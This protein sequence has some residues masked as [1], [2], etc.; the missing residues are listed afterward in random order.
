[1]TAATISAP[2]EDARTAR[3]R[4]AER[5][6]W[7]HYGLAPEERFVDVGSPPVRIRVVEVGSGP[8]V[9]VAHGTAG[10]GPVAAALLKE[11]PDRRFLLMD[12][13]GFGLSSPIRYSART[14]KQTVADLQRDVLDAVGIERAD[15]VGHSI[16]GVFALRLALAHPAR[17]RRVMLLGAGAIVAEAGVPTIIRLMASPFGAIMVRL[18]RSRRATI[19]MIRGSGHGPSLNDGR[20]PDVFVDWRTAVN[21]DTDSMSRE[22]DM[23]R[24]VVSGRGYRPELTL[25]DTELAGITQ[26][27][28]MLYGTADSVGSRSVWTRVMDVIP[29]GRLSVV[30]GAGHM[31][32]LDEPHRVASET[33]SF[34]AD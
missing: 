7:T 18:I 2:R 34:L 28:L 32:W 12:R 14:F 3:Y 23:V 20:I 17:V 19:S 6:L 5:E 11:L 9:F 15:V 10:S 4:Q 21:R 29:N 33:R 22:R 30:E 27:T 25:T 24:V 1:M 13:P 16:G 31:L 8:P 26:P